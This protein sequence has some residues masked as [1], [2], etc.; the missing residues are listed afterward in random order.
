[1]CKPRD[2][3]AAG[4]TVTTN[5]QAGFDAADEDLGIMDDLTGQITVT[6]FMSDYENAR[7]I[8]DTTASHASP[9]PPTPPTATPHSKIN[10]GS[11]Q[12]PAFGNGGRFFCLQER[13]WSVQLSPC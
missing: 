6:K 5:L 9:T 3:P 2:T 7:I 11:L 13:Q 12:R 4:K 8:V 1:M 10:G